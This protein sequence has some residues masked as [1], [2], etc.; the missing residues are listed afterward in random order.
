[1]LHVNKAKYISD[2]QIWLSFDDGSKGQVALEKYLTGSMFEPLKEIS[3]FSQVRF[4]K[5]LGTIT[6]PNGADL[7]PEFL[8][9]VIINF[10]KAQTVPAME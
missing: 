1:M 4:D 7:A 6:W 9:D 3:L 8:K 10:I 2:Y 5:E